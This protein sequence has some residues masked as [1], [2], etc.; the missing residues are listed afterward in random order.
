[1]S[2]QRKIDPKRWTQAAISDAKTSLRRS[3]IESLLLETESLADFEEM[4]RALLAEYQPAD[5][6]FE[7]LFL[8]SMLSAKWRLRRLQKFADALY[9]H[10]LEQLKKRAPDSVY[11]KEDFNLFADPKSGFSIQRRHL[12]RM[13]KRNRKEF[14]K[15]HAVNA[16]DSHIHA[17]PSDGGKWVH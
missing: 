9:A 3:F 1:M 16:S 2:T 5:D 6:P 14:L 15:H 13:F 10:H 4:E 12:E 11:V 17:L 8:E 7:R